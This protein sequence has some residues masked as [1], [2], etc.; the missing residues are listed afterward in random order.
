MCKCKQCTGKKDWGALGACCATYSDQHSHCEH[1]L[2]KDLVASHVHTA[3][4][5]A[6]SEA[7][8]RTCVAKL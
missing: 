5:H 7:R 3:V 8:A 4:M 1:T 6:V 2:T